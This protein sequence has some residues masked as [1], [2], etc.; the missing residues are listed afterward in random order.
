M[1]L[2]MDK[3]SIADDMGSAEASPNRI[4]FPQSVTTTADHSVCCAAGLT[5]YVAPQR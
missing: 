2:D 4:E 3:H 1:A 5:G